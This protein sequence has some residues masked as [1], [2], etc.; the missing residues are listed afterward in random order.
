M[1]NPLTFLSVALRAWSKSNRRTLTILKRRASTPPTCGLPGAR[2]RRGASGE[3]TTPTCPSRPGYAQVVPAM[4]KSPQPCE[5]PCREPKLKK[6]LNMAR[7]RYPSEA[8]PKTILR[9]RDSSHISVSKRNPPYA[10]SH[11][12]SRGCVKTYLYRYIVLG[13]ECRRVFTTRRITDT[14]PWNSVGFSRFFLF[15]YFIYA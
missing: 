10:A 5:D 9:C 8:V 4:R 2:P 11:N 7:T 12:G 6:Q 14:L 3:I 1:K 13:W 15:L